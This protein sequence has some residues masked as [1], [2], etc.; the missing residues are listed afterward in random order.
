M[1]SID[2]EVYTL[3]FWIGLDWIGLDWIGLD[4][5]GLDWIG[6]DWIFNLDGFIF[7]D[8]VLMNLYK[9]MFPKWTYDPHISDFIQV[10]V[11]QTFLRPQLKNFRNKLE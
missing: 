6:L 8:T 9:R 4:W 5:I 10:S 3:L 1:T 11:L 2:D 7:Q